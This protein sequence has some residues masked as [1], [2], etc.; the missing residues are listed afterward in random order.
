[1]SNSRS[2]STTWSTDP[3]F[4]CWWKL[5]DDFYKGGRGAALFIA[6]GQSLVELL[7]CRMTFIRSALVD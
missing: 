1:M 4:N 7:K 2:A 6:G 5:V 3:A